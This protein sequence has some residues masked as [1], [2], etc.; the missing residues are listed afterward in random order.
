MKKIIFILCGVFFCAT[1][2]GD[3][4]DT[5]TS[6]QGKISSAVAKEKDGYYYQSSGLDFNVPANTTVAQA[7]AKANLSLGCSGFDFN[8][9]FLKQFSV[10][11]LKTDVT[12]QAQQLLGAA[13]LLLLDYASPTLADMLKHFQAIVNGKLGLAVMSCQDI[14]NAVDDKFDKMRKE[15][16]KQ[17]IDDNS[18]MGV[19]AAVA[20]CKQQTDPFSFLK[21][22]KGVP[23]MQGGQIN[24]VA[25][26]LQRLGVPNADANNTLKIIG[27]TKI[28][29]GG[30]SDV[31][32]VESYQTLVEQNKDQNMTNLLQ[33]LVNYRNSRT[34]S[35]SDL[36]QFSR[37]G[38]QVNQ[39]FLD[40]LLI[41]PDTKRTEAISKLSSYLAYVDADESYRAAID[42]LN[43][44][45]GDPNTPET[46]KVILR[47]KRDIAEYELTKAKAHYADLLSLKN[48][49]AGIT[50]DSDTARQELVDSVDG[51]QYLTEQQDQ[52][53]KHTG[54]ITNW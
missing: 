19:T 31:G 10:E 51:T 48:T 29:K 34:V 23:L 46:Q 6:N 12:S 33:L 5:S 43:A 20:Y 8:A 41:L 42:K 13:P 22:I 44:A 53:A 4:F 11:A 14:E 39:S 17:C 18:G 40:N 25:D 27:D 30:Y 50:S 26:A 24:V 16:E 49:L 7:S 54:L 9:S 47:D 52:Q 35:S 45:I 3:V 37:P 32:Q 38:V 28:T 2:W 15:S 1:A 36:D 21:D